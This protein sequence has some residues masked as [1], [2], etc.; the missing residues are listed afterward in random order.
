MKDD[1]HIYYYDQGEDWIIQNNLQDMVAF[2]SF[3]DKRQSKTQKE[4]LDLS[5]YFVDTI[6]FEEEDY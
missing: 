5:V 1:K 2:N 6:Y 3:T 4:W